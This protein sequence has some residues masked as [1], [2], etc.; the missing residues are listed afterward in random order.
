VDD[1][2]IPTMLE[3]FVAG[4]VLGVLLC[5]DAAVTVQL[6]V[7]HAVVRTPSTGFPMDILRGWVV[8]GPRRTWAQQDEDCGVR[9]HDYLF[10]P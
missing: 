2:V 8:N 10:P 9:T 5:Q 7:H 6:L 3:P 4:H 1:V